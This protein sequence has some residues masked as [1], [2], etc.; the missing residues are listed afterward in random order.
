M[1]GWAGWLGAE[2]VIWG[3]REGRREGERSREREKVAGSGIGYVVV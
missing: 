2:A 1:D 3:D